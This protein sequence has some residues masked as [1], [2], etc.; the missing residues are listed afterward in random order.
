MAGQGESPHIL[1]CNYELIAEGMID[2]A[3]TRILSEITH[4]AEGTPPDAYVERKGDGLYKLSEDDI[5]A[6]LDIDDAPRILLRLLQHAHRV[7]MHEYVCRVPPPNSDSGTLEYQAWEKL[8][9][10]SVATSIMHIL[11]NAGLKDEA[12]EMMRYAKKE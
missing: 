9:H 7:A 11:I 3:R 10:D 5:L 6:W 8:M 12:M 2:M 1:P 4:L